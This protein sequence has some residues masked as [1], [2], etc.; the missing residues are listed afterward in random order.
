MIGRLLPNNYRLNLTEGNTIKNIWVL[1]FPIMLGNILQTAFNVVDMIWVGRLGEAAIASVAMS[2]GVLL[3]IITL[4]I[5]VSAATHSLIAR[6]TGAG[7]QQ[8]AENVAMQSLI[9]GTVLS[10]IL[11]AAGLIFARPILGLLGAKAQV[12]EL[13]TDYLKIILMGGVAMVYLFLICAIFRARGDAVTPMLIMIGATVLNVILDPLMIFGIGFPFMGVKGAALATVVSRGLAAF[14]GLYIL[15]RGSSTLRLSLVKLRADIKSIGNII[16]LGFPN[17]IQMALRSIAGLVLMAIVAQYGTY[18]LA[19]Y[20]IGLRIFSVV[21]MPGFALATSAA[22]LVGQNL[23]AKKLLRANTCA[24]QAAGFNSLL[25]G[26]VGVVFFVFSAQLIALFNT[27][28]DVVKLGT[29]YLKITSFGYVFVAQGLVLGR[30]LVGAGDSLSPMLISVVTLLGIQ[31]PL[32]VILPD[33]LK[34]GINGVW[35]AI[36]ISSVLQG[37]LTHFWFNLGLRRHF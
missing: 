20:G 27:N 8:A 5:G 36:L 33:Y 7:N 35:W 24:R 16:K 9:V 30:S 15:F 17:S 34:I 28:P 2:G 23:G 1:A 32:A 6:F 31:L 4:V 25:M 14:L 37:I 11:A 21:L 22:T 3:V 29:E 13:G 19:A 26:L 10:V 18:A 12:L